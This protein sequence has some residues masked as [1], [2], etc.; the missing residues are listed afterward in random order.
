MMNMPPFAH[1][2]V[3][4]RHDEA[5]NLTAVIAMHSTRLG[6]AAGGCRRWRYADVGEAITDAL[7]LSEGMTLKN[8]LAGLPFGGGKSVILADDRPR[9]TAEQ[10]AVFAGWLNELNGRYVTAEDVGMGVAEMRSMAATSPY[11]SGLG[12]D[13][14]G[15]DP[16]PKTAYGVFV[17]L[18]TAVQFALGVEHLHGVRVGVQGLGAV[19]MSLCHWLVRA[20]AEVTATDINPARV[21]EARERYGVRGVGPDELLKAEMDV[22]APCALGGVIDDEVASI[23]D[24]RV[25]A[26]AANNQLLD[27]TAGEILAERGVVYAPD[28]VINAGGVISVAHEYLLQRGQFTE[29]VDHSVER[30]VGERIDAISH[31]LLDILQQAAASG[32]S[33]D[34][35]ARRLAREAVAAGRVNPARA[36]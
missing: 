5:T 32:T 3:E 18:K 30:W 22:F 12:A 17:G 19:G 24:V 4:I 26:G 8:A 33:T 9:P 14:I 34:G 15:G 13:G 25:V 27:A 7:R 29:T 20:G 16:S 28:F 1:E 23:L 35:V 2:R 36:A 11:V 21:R 10:L 6:P 31:R